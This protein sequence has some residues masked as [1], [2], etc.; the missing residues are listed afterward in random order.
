MNQLKVVN[1]ENDSYKGFTFTNDQQI[2]IDTI[3][4]FIA[5]SFNPAKYIIGLS[6]AG[7]TGKTFITNYIITH[8]KYASSVIKCA[9]PTHKACRVLSQ[10]INGKIV[11]TIQSIFGLRL[12]L[13]LEDFDP[14]RP[15]F[16][17]MSTP[18]LENVKLLIIDEA[19]MLPAKLVGYICKKCKELQIKIIFIGDAY[20]LAPVNE[21]KS[22]AFER[23]YVVCYLN[24]VVRQ[25][26]DNPITEL[27][28]LLRKDIK[29]KTYDFLKFIGSQIG[30]D[31]Y[32]ENGEGY[33]V[34]TPNK[35]KE[36]IDRS[37]SNEEYTKNIDM[38]R[39]IAY[40]NNC[41]AGWNNYIR[42]S[43]IKDA[44]K[45]II[46]KNDL[47]MS[48]ETIIDDFL[49]SII[50]NSEEYIINDIVDFVDTQYGIKG[51]LVKFQLIH[52][53]KITKPLFIVDHRDRYSIS[54]YI[55]TIKLL[56]EDAKKATGA[57][58]VSKW[59]AYYAFKKKFLIAANI[60]NSATGNIMYSRDIDYGFAITSHKSQGSTYDNIF[61]DVNN[62]VYNSNGIP[63]SDQD[64]LLRRLYVGCSRA[65]S[66]LILCYGRD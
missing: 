44:D 65:K 36:I 58:R 11:N 3:I 42:H 62:I 59:K 48:Y 21:R 51:F 61:V 45:S 26:A 10:A 35:F 54:I 39:I 53:G 34:C 6:G 28:A 24:E 1:E 46:T 29:N 32:N 20:Q 37:F 52:G 47:I 19:S 12:D 63:Y 40:T 56:I 66:K 17:P 25:G 31:R 38:Y 9:S 64:D 43:I 14:N 33:T 30:V 49:S 13:K 8:C 41:V 16:N 57:T 15:Q 23:C 60:I 18:K 2:A 22:I 27:L 4:Q 5:D 50:D 55:K 7:G